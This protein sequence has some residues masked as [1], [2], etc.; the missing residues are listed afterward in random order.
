L[1]FQLSRFIGYGLDKH[2]ERIFEMARYCREWASSNFKLFP[3]PGYEA[4]GLTAIENTKGIDLKKLNE[5]LAKRGTIISRGYGK[6]KE[7]TFRIAHMGDITLEEIRQLLSMI[8][9]IVAKL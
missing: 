9:K 4:V 8:D 1:D 2:F 3:E 6:L 7:K 5:E